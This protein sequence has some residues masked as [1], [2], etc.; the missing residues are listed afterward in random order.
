MASILSTFTVG[1]AKGPDGDEIEMDP[2]AL[3][4]DAIRQ[5]RFVILA[6]FH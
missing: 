5:A 6:Y 1:K 3:T 2:D 4:G